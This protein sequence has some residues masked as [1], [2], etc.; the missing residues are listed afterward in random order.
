MHNLFSLNVVSYKLEIMIEHKFK[1][2]T[3]SY[4]LEF[5]NAHFRGVLLI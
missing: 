5:G 4:K 3:G 1:I 2:A